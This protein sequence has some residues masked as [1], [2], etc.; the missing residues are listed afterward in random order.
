M[1]SLLSMAPVF[2]F[3]RKKRKAVCDFYD[4][5]SITNVYAYS[6]QQNMC[7]I[8]HE[9]LTHYYEGWISVGVILTV[10]LRDLS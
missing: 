1:H 4:L 3:C 10:V 8:E 6:R 5:G 9:R 2:E 7:A